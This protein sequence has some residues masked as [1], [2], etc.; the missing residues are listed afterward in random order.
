MQNG[1]YKLR[2]EGKFPFLA[3]KMRE[4]FAKLVGK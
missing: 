3:D 2:S 4:I 1:I